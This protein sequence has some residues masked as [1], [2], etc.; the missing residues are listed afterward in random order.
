MKTD[1]DEW[2]AGEGTGS[3][4]EFLVRTRAPRCVVAVDEPGETV[5]AP[6]VYVNAYGEG[7]YVELWMDPEPS[8]TAHEAILK[9]AA[10]ALDA[11]TERAAQANEEDGGQD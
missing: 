9:E 7:F 5:L 8:K 1:L 11:F 10:Q 3:G 4:R 6:I 2:I